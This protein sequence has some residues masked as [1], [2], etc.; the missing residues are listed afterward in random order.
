MTPP[1]PVDQTHVLV[2]VMKDALGGLRNT[3]EAGHAPLPIIVGL[4]HKKDIQGQA[5]AF[6]ALL[7]VS[8]MVRLFSAINQ[9]QESK[10]QSPPLLSNPYHA[11][12]ALAQQVGDTYRALTAG[13]LASMFAQKTN[14]VLT[15]DQTMKRSGLHSYVTKTLFGSIPSASQA[16]LDSLDDAMT[17]LIQ[18]LKLFKMN[19]SATQP[20]VDFCVI[21]NFVKATDITR[22]NSAF[23]YEPMTRVLMLKVNVDNW[24][25]TI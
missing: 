21:S 19:S 5:H 18:V 15:A 17:D 6:A 23:V 14:T 16:V 12:L 20:T 25:H 8:A 3:T 4:E 9:I 1:I 11:P 2:G 22:T 10:S 13:M 7:G 24:N